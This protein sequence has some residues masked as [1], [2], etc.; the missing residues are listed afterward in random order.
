MSSNTLNDIDFSAF[1]PWRTNKG[2]KAAIAR[3][4][5]LNGENVALNEITDATWP[6]RVE[7]LN[8]GHSGRGRGVIY[9]DRELMQWRWRVNQGRA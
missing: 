5:E 3:I 1:S 2:R 6:K 7:V 8:Y 4:K 9:S